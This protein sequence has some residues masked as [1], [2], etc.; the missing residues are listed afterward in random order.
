[1]NYQVLARKWRPQRFTDVIGQQHVLTA[2]VNALSQG[3]LHHAYLFSGT[4]GVGKTSI[5]RLLAKALNC[6]KGIT[7]E[8]CGV[9]SS[10]V[11]IEQGRFVD[12]LEI[13][14]A[15]RTKVEDTRELLDNV[16]YQPA[17]G[18]FKVYLIDE[19]HMLSRHSFNALLKTL[20]EPPPHV[21]F[22]L[23]TTDPQKLPITILSRCLQF[24]LKSLAPELIDGQLQHILRQE[25]LPFEV[26]AT[27]A[28]ARAADGSVRDALSLTDQALAF[29]NG[30]IR[31]VQVEAMLGNL[32]HNQLMS[33]VNALLSGDGAAM[34]AQ[35]GELASMGPDYDH[36]HKELVGF[37]HQLALAQIVP[38][39]PLLPYA[40]ELN[41]L[42][43][44]ISP[45]HIQLFYQICLQGRK[46]LPFAADGRAALEMTLLRSLAFQPNA[47][48][49]SPPSAASATVIANTADTVNTGES[50]VTSTAE[51]AVKKPEPP[52][53]MP[54]SIASEPTSATVTHEAVSALMPELDTHSESGLQPESDAQLA[55]QLYHEQ[56]TILAQAVQFGYEPKAV[57]APVSVESAAS[58]QDEFEAAPP[59]AITPP[60]AEVPTTAAPDIA[61]PAAANVAKIRSL[62]QTRNRLRS[63]DTTDSAA[64][65][66][67]SRQAKPSYT[68]PIAKPAAPA[69]GS[70]QVTDAH[71]GEPRSGLAPVTRPTP[72]QA[73]LSGSLDQNLNQQGVELPPL[74]AYN[75]MA[76]QQEDDD[77]PPWLDDAGV[78]PSQPTSWQPNVSAASGALGAT[79]VAPLRAASS[80]KTTTAQPKVQVARTEAG[81]TNPTATG[82]P[83][84]FGTA[85]GLRPAPSKTATDPEPLKPS[86]LLIQATDAWTSLVAQLPLGGLLR[87]LAMHSS[88]EQQAANQWQLWL[89]PEHRHLLNDSA[90]DELAA[91]LSEQQQTA[92][93]LQVQVGEQSGSLTPFEIEQQLYQNAISQ[94]KDEIEA[95]DAV[96]FLISRFA[97]ELDRDSIEPMAQ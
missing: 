55:A 65:L 23:A 47:A 95:D 75:D 40:S 1:M 66:D 20:E 22:L 85:T 38:A 27:A 43:P 9:C 56:D 32:N 39:Q 48:L 80:P 94:A 29:G 34:L 6:D 57:M 81:A 31:L 18:R 25:H 19:V 84:N 16:Q 13:D 4:R 70:Q 83:L 33:L 3:R 41:R 64:P 91:L 76:N 90:R 44:L 53:I 62:L 87:Q 69:N 17:R 67:A 2:L 92:I 59:S 89:K 77:L 58:E 5:A 63:Q 14:A 96:Q 12:L 8:P 10:C 82:A 7:P 24:H 60:Q 49:A 21:K 37:W 73:G 26:E 71:T 30:E 97:A 93:S 88:L 50:P 68:A 61:D 35:V 42:A 79:Q 54:A 52:R 45:E 46:D 78:G 72:S 51:A 15:S 36:I 11:E 28:L 74:D 86:S